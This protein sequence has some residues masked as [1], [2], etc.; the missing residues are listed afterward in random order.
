MRSVYCKGVEVGV[1]SCEIWSFLLTMSKMPCQNKTKIVLLFSL[2][3][4]FFEGGL[5]PMQC[6]LPGGLPGLV[7]VHRKAVAV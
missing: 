4:A 5:V 7:Y 1:P 2:R 3:L 6:G